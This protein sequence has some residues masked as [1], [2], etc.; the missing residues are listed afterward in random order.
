[1]KPIPVE[2]PFH[3]IG[4]D[5][6]GPLPETTKENKFIIVATDYLTKWP[7]AKAVPAANAQEAANFIYEDIICRHGCPTY[8]LSDR[9][10]HFLNELVHTLVQ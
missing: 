9:G 8:L 5:Y 1:M 6:V 3:R 4:I 7:E 2:A 10:R